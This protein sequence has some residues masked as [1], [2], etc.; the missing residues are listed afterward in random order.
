MEGICH[1]LTRNFGLI[2]AKMPH[3]NSAL[4][5]TRLKL[6]AR[7]WINDHLNRYFERLQDNF[8]H[9]VLTAHNSAK[10]ADLLSQYNS[11]KAGQDQAFR[12]FSAHI[13]QL[14]S[15][16]RTYEPGIYSDLDSL[17]NQ[18]EKLP[19]PQFGHEKVQL[20][21]FCQAVSPISLLAGFQRMIVPLK[22]GHI[23]RQQAL[24]MFQGLFIQ[25]L[26]KLY[27]I[28]Q[29]SLL[30]QNQAHSPEDWINHSK[31]QLAEKSLSSQQH[32]LTELRLQRLL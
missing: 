3:I 16:K 12:L 30:K 21:Y 9:R 28:V 1:S 18:L 27:E 14:F 26:G 22:L 7:Q 29:T 20:Q 19:E 5:S 8:H 23:H 32:A 13:T 11:V 24:T 17:A 2:I 10:Q 4:L 6:Q 25:Q 31:K 15:T